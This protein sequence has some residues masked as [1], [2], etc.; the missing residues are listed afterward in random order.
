[1]GHLSTN[2]ANLPYKKLALFP[3]SATQMQ[4]KHSD[5]VYSSNTV[6][7][8]TASNIHVANT[9]FAIFFKH[10]KS[11]HSVCLITH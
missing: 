3:D 10:T 8:F 1:M 4:F 7:R 9:V 2:T 5:Q 6:F 11:K